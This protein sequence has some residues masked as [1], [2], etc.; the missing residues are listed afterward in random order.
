MKVHRTLQIEFC[1]D[2]V[3]HIANGDGEKRLIDDIDKNWGKVNYPIEGIDPSDQWWE[4]VP[5]NDEGF[6]SHYGCDC[7][8]GTL[9]GM[10]YDGVAM[11][12][13]K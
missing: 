4:L 11:L 9:S 12:V 1:G 5:G 6:F 7:C 8:G 3:V 10:R 2:C 13:S